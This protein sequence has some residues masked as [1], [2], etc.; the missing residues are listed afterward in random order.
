M[1]HNA[2]QLLQRVPHLAVEGFLAHVKRS[3]AKCCS[4]AMLKLANDMMHLWICGGSCYGLTWAELRLATSSPSTAANA[5]TAPLSSLASVNLLVP[6]VLAFFE[7]WTLPSFADAA[8][9]ARGW[10]C[11]TCAAKSPP[12]FQA[13]WSEKPRCLLTKPTRQTHVDPDRR[14]TALF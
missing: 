2:W 12:F 13:N 14:K 11:Q 1:L 4:L 8:G 5:S 10:L 7:S 3:F 9:S 6:A